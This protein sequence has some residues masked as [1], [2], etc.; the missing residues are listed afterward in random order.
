VKDTVVMDIIKRNLI[1]RFSECDLATLTEEIS[2]I[3][4]TQFLVAFTYFEIF[5]SEILTVLEQVFLTIIDQAEAKHSAAM[6]INHSRWAQDMLKYDFE[7]ISKNKRKRI[8]EKQL[9]LLNKTEKVFRQYND[10]LTMKIIESLVMKLDDINLNA[11]IQIQ[12]NLLANGIKKNEA[13]R[14]ILT[15]LISGLKVFRNQLQSDQELDY[16]EFRGLILRYYNDS[17]PF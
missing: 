10:E 4:L 16:R 13:R 15:F 8:K 11:L 5:D 3:D 17:K 9:P 6:L 12:S 7:G 2:S 1:K 14:T